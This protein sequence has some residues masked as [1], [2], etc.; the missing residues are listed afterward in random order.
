[1]RMASVVNA[2]V[3][4]V[5]SNIE[6]KRH[7]FA[8]Y[9]ARLAKARPDAGFRRRQELKF[10]DAGNCSGKACRVG[11]SVEDQRRRRMNGSDNFE[12]G[13]FVA[14]RDAPPVYS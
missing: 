2:L 8:V 3:R 1:M 5:L 4:P 10:G 9:H 13:Q 14:F 7:L 11:H 6:V 12:S